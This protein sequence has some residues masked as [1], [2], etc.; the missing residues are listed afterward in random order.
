MPISWPGIAWEITWESNK[1]IFWGE[2]V[3][4]QA[5]F[6]LGEEVRISR[7]GL[8]PAPRSEKADIGSTENERTYGA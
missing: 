3:R 2:A 6:P 4:R 1:T 8:K 5:A 7:L